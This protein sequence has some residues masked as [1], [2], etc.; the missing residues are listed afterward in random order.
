M[1]PLRHHQL[2]NVNRELAFWFAGGSVPAAL[3]GTFALYNLFGDNVSSWLP[4]LIGY[5]LILVG[6]AVVIRTF[7]T[8]RGLIDATKV[9]VDGELQT[10]HKVSAV[11]IGLV[12]GF[13]LGLTSVGAGVF[14]GMAMVTLYPLSTRKVVGTDIFHGAMVTL[15]AAVGTILW[16]TPDFAVI[17]SLIDRL[18]PGHPDRLALHGQDESA[19]A[20]QL[21][22]R[23]ARRL[24]P[25]APRRLVVTV[26]ES[27]VPGTSDSLLI[28]PG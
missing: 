24:R 16:G 25:Q 5:M 14:F 7:V 11:V 17:G 19:G 28:T 4:R 1:A 21:D 8:I 10:W 18:D 27:G 2:Q 3:F 15:A 22:R 26:G 20:A 9:P 23:R 12:F 13:L 6:I